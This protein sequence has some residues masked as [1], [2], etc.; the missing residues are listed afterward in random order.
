MSFS[1]DE[2]WQNRKDYDSKLIATLKPE[3]WVCPGLT[4]PCRPLLHL[5]G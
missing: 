1:T 2:V 3:T 4:P 5:F